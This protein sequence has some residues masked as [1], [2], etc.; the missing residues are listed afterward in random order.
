MLQSDH[1]RRDHPDGEQH[2]QRSGNG[3]RIEEIGDNQEIGEKDDDHRVALPGHL[4]DF[5][6]HHDRQ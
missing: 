3:L 2:I 5:Q 4:H 6:G 1:R